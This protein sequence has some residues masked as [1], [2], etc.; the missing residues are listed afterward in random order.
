[1]RRLSSLLALRETPFPTDGTHLPGCFSSK[2][3][4]VSSNRRSNVLRLDDRQIFPTYE[5]SI[6]LLR[7]APS[8]V[9]IAERMRVL[10]GFAVFS[11][12]KKRRGVVS[13]HSVI[14]QSREMSPFYVE[15]WEQFARTA[16]NLAYGCII[17]RHV[18]WTQCNGSLKVMVDAPLLLY[19][20]VLED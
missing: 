5:K 6:N 11:I 2:L 8:K 19:L 17:R 7:G 15:P 1:M 16:R 4:V 9:T 14:I 18:G 20:L 3:L 10:Y 12:E 13:F